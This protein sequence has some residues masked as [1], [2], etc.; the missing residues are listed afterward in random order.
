MKIVIALL[1]A[2]ASAAVGTDCKTN[3]SACGSGECCGVGKKDTSI[4]DNQA[5]TDV[6]VCNTDKATKYTDPTNAQKIY[7]FTCN[8][9]VAAKSGAA[10][11]A[12]G[13]SFVALASYYMA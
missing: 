10:N 2:S 9:A 7:T 8:A 12:V 3:A 1:V 6:T 4:N 13:A 11:L 5:T